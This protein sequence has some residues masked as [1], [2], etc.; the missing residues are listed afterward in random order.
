MAPR[1]IRRLSGL[2]LADS[3][4]TGPG[5]FTAT[6]RLLDVPDRQGT[7]GMMRGRQV[8]AVGAEAEDEDLAIAPGLKRA[9]SSSSA[10]RRTWIVPSR[11]RSA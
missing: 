9:I 6:V 10:T 8:A 4:V 3:R 11:N 7:A 2:N 1:A 5:S